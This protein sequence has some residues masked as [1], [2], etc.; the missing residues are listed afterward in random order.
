M[1]FS[2]TE[3]EKELIRD[4]VEKVRAQG[5]TH[6]DFK[7]YM[8]DAEIIE[9]D[10][11]VVRYEDREKEH[12][13]KTLCS[14]FVKMIK[15]FENARF[16]VLDKQTKIIEN[17]KS[18]AEEAIIFAYNT[19]DLGGN[20]GGITIS[21][22]KISDNNYFNI[23]I[24]GSPDKLFNS[25]IEQEKTPA[26]IFTKDGVRTF[27]LQYAIKKHIEA[28]KGTPGEQ[29]LY[30]AIEKCLEKS[31]YISCEELKGD[32]AVYEEKNPIHYGKYID[33]FF[34]L[35]KQE[36]PADAK[37]NL[38]E[39]DREGK[40]YS[41]NIS[42]PKGRFSVATDQL[43]LSSGAEFA[44][45][46]NYPY[47]KG[48]KKADNINYTVKIPL[49]GYA[50]RR[51]YK[52]KEEPKATPQEREKEKK[53]AQE[54][55]KT[56]RKRIK[57]DLDILYNCSFSWSEKINGE[58]EDFIDIRLLEARGIRNGY[59]NITFSRSYA[60]YLLKHRA[61]TQFDNRLLLIDGNHENAYFLAN[62]IVNHNSM[63]KNQE[64]GTANILSVKKL[65]EYSNLPS[66][67]ELKKQRR[68]WE[69]RIK[70]P[71]E[72]ILDYLVFDIKILKDWKYTKAKGEEL[73]AEEA[74]SITDY[75]NF[76]KLYITFSMNE[77]EEENN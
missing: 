76:E 9:E 31:K 18:T 6:V 26:R 34:E 14:E 60:N 46:N 73:S 40:S 4:F 39:L 51:G 63:T 20:G 42:S 66:I 44:K 54:A 17:A 32:F 30:K 19:I 35:V 11:L 56:A 41:F 68:G 16:S 24:N 74:E 3:E 65:L 62:K 64:R 57:R 55:L 13:I 72:N 27:L 77:S 25:H 70:D 5:I 50:E 52:V 7:R 10:L 36:Q 67:E 8:A 29:K 23:A 49:I 45:I 22:F 69:K 33:N 38:I 12:L 28:L 61:M 1:I 75:A 43:L 47:K 2:F 58:E 37:E 59:I 53:R 15:G 21:S 48:D 71:L